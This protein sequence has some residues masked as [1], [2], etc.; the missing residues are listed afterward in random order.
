MSGWGAFA[1]GVGGAAAQLASKYIDEELTQQRAQ[2]LSDI[3][4]ASNKRAEE[5]TQSDEVQGRRRA[6]TAKDQEQSR[7]SALMQAAAIHKQGNQLKIS[8]SQDP[9]LATVAELAAADATRR[10]VARQDALRPG[11]IATAEA[12]SRIQTDGQIKVERERQAGRM[13]EL[14]AT[15]KR[16]EALKTAFDRLPERTKLEVQTMAGD[17][18]DINKAITEAQANGQWEPA[19]IPGQRELAQR[20]EKLAFRIDALLN[21]DRDED[22]LG[23]F[24][25]KAEQS[26]RAAPKKDAAPEAKKTPAQPARSLGDESVFKGMSDDE[27]EK[28]VRAGNQ[29]AKQVAAKRSK[30]A[31]QDAV[32]SGFTQGY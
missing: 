27:L 3:Q 4:F 7:A 22:R 30:Q 24:S 6:N 25:P 12:T 16:K 2:A 31:E 9:E 14:N 15:E 32:N 19:K 13:V 29:V 23:L 1:G 26:E 5:Y 18:K 28:Y 20:K 11:A 8:D 17:L 10:E 21:P